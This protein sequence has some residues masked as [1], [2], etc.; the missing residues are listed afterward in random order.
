[1]EDYRLKKLNRYKNER[2]K[3]ICLDTD[4]NYEDK[5]NKNIKK[6]FV[7]FR[8]NLEEKIRI[9]QLQNGTF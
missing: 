7:K 9:K 8:K 2:C 1:M 3:Y 6:N 5:S 4:D